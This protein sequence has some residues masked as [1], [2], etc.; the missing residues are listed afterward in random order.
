MISRDRRAG[1]ATGSGPWI[2]SFLHPKREFGTA[3]G[4]SFYL[5]KFCIRKFPLPWLGAAAAIVVGARAGMGAWA[6]SAWA[7]GT[8]AR[9]EEW[10]RAAMGCEKEADSHELRWRHECGRVSREGRSGPR[11]SLLGISTSRTITFCH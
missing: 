4:S 3:A 7:M 9:R 8:I 11:P 1:S 2:S 10:A 5:R 6:Q